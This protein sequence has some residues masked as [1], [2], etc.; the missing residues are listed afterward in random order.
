MD[1]DKLLRW[2]EF[3]QKMYG[4][5]FLSEIF[6]NEFLSGF[7]KMFAT[8][9]NFPRAD[10]FKNQTEIIVL[11]EIPGLNK[12]DIKLTVLGNRL[13]IKGVVR[14]PYPNHTSVTAERFYGPFERTI[15]LPEIVSGEGVSAK[16]NNGLLEVRLRRDLRAAAQNIKI[17]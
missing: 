4:K 14:H 3:A 5:D 15:Q 10:V 17:E 7:W 6:N 9:S 2:Q 12:D 8:E 1:M 16:F 13:R 11:M